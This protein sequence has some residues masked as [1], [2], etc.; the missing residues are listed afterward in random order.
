MVDDPDQLCPKKRRNYL[1]IAAGEGRLE[2]VRWLLE[3]GATP[4]GTTGL[5]TLLHSAAEM[6]HTEICEMLIAAGASL[7][8]VEFDLAG[9]TPL[10]LAL[11]YGHAQT[12]DALALHAILPRNLRIA[13]GIGRVD[14]LEELHNTVNAGRERTW[15]H[16][17]DGYPDWASSDNP[18]EILDEAL[19]YAATNGRFEVVRWLLERGARAD[20]MPY[21]VTAV[22]QA[23]W[24]K[25]DDVLE[26]LLETGPDLSI[27]DRMHDG[28]PA[29]WAREA[30]RDELVARL[31]GS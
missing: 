4:D 18:Q 1:H 27:L 8:A 2:S 25:H 14:I 7:A 30:G 13:A 22:H 12:A 5:W 24:Y 10:V 23:I 31:K 20:A 29:D 11:F 6:G 16:P 21:D 26:A 9:G 19:V 3:S 15:Y 17:H 28:T